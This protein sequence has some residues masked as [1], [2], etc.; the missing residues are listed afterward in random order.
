MPS[1]GTKLP[2][3]MAASPVL[4]DS[5]FYIRL[6]R[7]GQDPLKS[8]ALAAATR[9]L[10][11]CGIVRCEVGRALRRPKVRQQFHAFWDVMINVPTDNRLWKQ[12]E[13]TLWELDRRGTILPLT[14]A[15]IAC[16]AQRIDAVV[17]TYDEHFSLIPGVRTTHQL[18]L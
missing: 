13:Q 15:V 6:L 1:V 12:A 9:D 10:A 14:D 17:L 8:L 3:A 7:Q 5:S 11:I 4:A 16:C 18:E 2:H